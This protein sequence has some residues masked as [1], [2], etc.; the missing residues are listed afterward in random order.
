MFIATLA[1]EDADPACF[2][3]AC[4]CAVVDLIVQCGGN[5]GAV[6]ESAEFGVAHFVLWCDE[7]GCW[8][9]AQAGEL[10]RRGEGKWNVEGCEELVELELGFSEAFGLHSWAIGPHTCTLDELFVWR[11]VEVVC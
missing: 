10:V 2:E 3:L 1:I 4:K 9:G 6:Q 7:L 5:K 11:T 8:D